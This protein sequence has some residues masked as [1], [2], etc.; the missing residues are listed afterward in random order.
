MV[1]PR[2]RKLN[3]HILSFFQLTDDIV[4][5]QYLEATVSDLEDLYNLSWVSLTLLR[6]AAEKIFDCSLCEID[7]IIVPAIL[8][9][10][11]L[12]ADVEA[13]S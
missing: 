12:E 13:G 1:A 6:N 3:N 7:C 10:G 4:I 9:A 5:N 11:C 8:S 2:S